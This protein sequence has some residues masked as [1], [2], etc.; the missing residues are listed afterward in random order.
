MRFKKLISAAVAS[1]ILVSS[2]TLVTNVQAEDYKLDLLTVPFDVMG[3]AL[4]EKDDFNR[5][6][7]T[8]LGKGYYAVSGAW[9]GN[10]SIV[11]ITENDLA[12]WRETGDFSFTK[13][14]YDGTHINDDNLVDFDKGDYFSI[15]DYESNQY[16]LYKLDE[17]T[18][19]VVKLNTIS[20]NDMFGTNSYIFG[21]GDSFVRLDGYTARYTS[22]YGEVKDDKRYDVLTITLIAPDGTETT[23]NFT[24]EF[25]NL[26]IKLAF[27]SNYVCYC[28]IKSGDD[29]GLYSV[30]KEG[31]VDFISA[32]SVPDTGNM[33]SW[34]GDMTI[35]DNFIYFDGHNIEGGKAQAYFYDIENDRLYDTKLH[36]SAEVNEYGAKDI[37]YYFSDK[38]YSGKVIANE[39]KD[40]ESHY[41]IHDIINDKIF[42]YTA[43]DDTVPEITK[44]FSITTNDGEIYHLSKGNGSWQNS[45]G[46]GYFENVNGNEQFKEVFNDYRVCMEFIGDYAPVTIDE[47]TYLIDRKF[48]RVSDSVDGT[49]WLSFGDGLYTVWSNSEQLLMT[50][51]DAA[52]AP[53]TDPTETQP[54]PTEPSVPNPP[55]TNSPVTEPSFETSET[56]ATPPEVDFTE[57]NNESN[58]VKIEFANGAVSQGAVLEVKKGTVTNTSVTYDISLKLNDKVIQ[59][60]GTI[61]VKIT[62]PENLTGDKFY[63]YRIESDGSYT[64]MK[65]EYS[66]DYITF[67]TSHFSEYIIS[68]LP[69]TES[70]ETVTT[71]DVVTETATPSDITTSIEITT[72]N[73]DNVDNANNDSNVPTGNVYS[74]FIPIIA[75]ASGITAVVAYNKKKK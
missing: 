7:M 60:N 35:Y 30:D 1:V 62:V 19:S 55:I 12:K 9:D 33:G 11:R 25:A 45:T 53:V 65:A 23:A 18:N 44:Y 49:A 16:S 5:Y 50:Y 42:A 69:L 48:N 46:Y 56:T 73:T 15:F 10:N 75:F 54:T 4:P 52:S 13:V 70:A 14:N 22:N 74:V 27:D 66:D 63:V 26:S 39:R 61:T 20:R 43:S 32:L 47:K 34:Y 17:A 31:N 38:M 6:S 72:I 59:P 21:R 24:Y 64:D 71:T 28:F 8:S 41:Y 3:D 68:T 58:K 29:Q 67:K 40:R 36:D 37:D 57:L 2:F 51:C